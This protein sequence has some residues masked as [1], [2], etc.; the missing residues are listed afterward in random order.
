MGMKEGIDI[1]LY[2]LYMFAAT[3][4]L[5]YFNISVINKE[6][7]KP[8]KYYL[9]LPVT[10]SSL[11]I[12]IIILI[13][14]MFFN[15]NLVIL[16]LTFFALLVLYLLK[17]NIPKPTGKWYFIFPIIAILITTLILIFI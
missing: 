15:K 1:C 9:G 6:N 14:L 12:P 8:V 7:N 13:E 10:Y 2:L 17:I 11:V 16:R 3:M 5:A 4:R